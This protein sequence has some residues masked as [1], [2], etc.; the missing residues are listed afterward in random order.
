MTSMTLLRDMHWNA[1]AWGKRLLDLVFFAMVI[2]LAVSCIRVVHQVNHGATVQSVRVH[3][4]FRRLRRDELSALLAQ[5]VHGSFMSVD[6]ESVRQAAM[7][8]PWVEQA[9]VSR[10]WPDSLDVQVRERQPVAHW[11]S[12]SYI[13]SRGDVFTPS[14]VT[15]IQGLPILY[16]PADQASYVMEQYRAMNAILHPLGIH[17]QSLEL[18]E[19]MSWILQLDNGLQ[20]KV[21]RED[22]LTKLQRFVLLYQREL[23][24]RQ[25][26]IN[27]VDL[28]Y[29][30]GIAVAWKPVSTTTSLFR[31]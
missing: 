13:S 20:V 31:H 8:S 18:T 1:P 3:G 24:S 28:R 17:V 30:N 16:G 29:H 27:S 6:L 2:V 25:N 19:R 26:Q 22:T 23:A 15:L 5:S 14:Q 9:R 10:I 12:K 7:A 4:D 11:G 21:D